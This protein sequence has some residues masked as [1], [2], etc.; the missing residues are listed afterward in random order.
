[1]SG[2]WIQTLSGRRVDV[3]AP[4]PASLVVDDIATALSHVCRF[5]GHVP[6]HYS[7]AQHSWLM[8]YLV[9]E[10]VALEALMHDAAEAYLG[11]VPR[12]IKL[13]LSDYRAVSDIMDAAI[14]AKW[15]LVYPWPAAVHESDMRMVMT[16][17]RTFGRDTADWGI[18]ADP[19]GIEITQFDAGSVAAAWRNR[20]RDLY[21]A[22]GG[23]VDA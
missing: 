1:M 14:A 22:R 23:N 11:D 12:P 17:A 5:S 18:D 16:E 7:V 9:P 19:Y 10:P 13:G 2:R 21:T 8:S 3:F 15:G 6:W 4:D 20:F